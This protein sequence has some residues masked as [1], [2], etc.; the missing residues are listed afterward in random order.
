VLYIKKKWILGED[1][2]R[3]NKLKIGDIIWFKGKSILQPHIYRI[4]IG[5]IKYV[6][7]N[8]YNLDLTIEILY[9]ISKKNLGIFS[10]YDWTIH[11]GDEIEKL[12]K[13]EA[14]LYVI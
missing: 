8:D 12:S 9:Q 13:K 7:F 10:E 5:K 4:A 1:R 3:D 6:D 11:D 2:K 14:F